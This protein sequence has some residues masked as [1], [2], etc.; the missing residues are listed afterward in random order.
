MSAPGAPGTASARISKAEWATAALG[1]LL[2][3][4][5]VGVLLYEGLARPTTPPDVAV[6]VERVTPVRAGFLLEFVAEN[7]GSKTAAG[8]TVRGE[9]RAPGDSAG[10]PPLEE[11]EAGLDY[12][13]GRSERKGGL[14]F[15]LDPRTHAVALQ[16]LGYQEP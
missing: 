2:V 8:L 6:R 13:P 11:R 7:M 16:A 5:A 10:A 3:L 15:T 9:L 12:L 4:A 1:V 14:F